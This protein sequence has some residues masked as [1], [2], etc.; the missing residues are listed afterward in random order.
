MWSFTLRKHNFDCVYTTQYCVEF[1]VAC[2]SH[3]TSMLLHIVL[4]LLVLLVSTQSRGKQIITSLHPLHFAKARKRSIIICHCVACI[5]NLPTIKAPLCKG[6]C[7]L[8][9]LGDCIQYKPM[10]VRLNLRKRL[11]SRLPSGKTEGLFLSFR[12][13]LVRRGNLIRLK[14]RPCVR[15][16]VHRRWWKGCFDCVSTSQKLLS[17]RLT[18]I[19]AVRKTA[20]A[21]EGL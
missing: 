4:T 9:G 6:G 19:Y 16:G 10:R 11:Y 15:E 21:V 18:R 12:A 17:S 7:P 20:V 8:C 5:G 2:R 13:L 14:S 3:T 1:A